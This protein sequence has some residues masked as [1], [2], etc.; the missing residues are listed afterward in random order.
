MIAMPNNLEGAVHGRRAGRRSDRRAAVGRQAAITV[1]EI[2]VP[3][4]RRLVE[5]V[6]AASM[7]RDVAAFAA[8][9]LLATMLS[10]LPSLDLM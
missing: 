10:V 2:V 4:P 9:V 1:R 5:A 7:V 6:A 8:L 3:A